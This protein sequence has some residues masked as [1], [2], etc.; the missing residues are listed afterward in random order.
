M[1]QNKVKLSYE[2]LWKFIIRPPRDEYTEDMLGNQKFKFHGKRYIRKDYEIISSQGYIMKC[3]LIEP[4]RGYRPFYEMP[5]VL[6]LHG[7]SSSRIEGLNIAHELLKRNINLFVVDFP[8]C[9][10]SEG[11]YISLGYHESDDVGIIIDFL[12]K[13]PGVGKIGM[14]GRSM[15]AATT[16]IYAHRDERVKAICMDSPFADFK[17][18]AKEL[19]K[20]QINIPDFLIDAVLSFVRTTVI[21]KNGLDI[22]KLKPLDLACKTHQPA[23]FLHAIYDELINV[24]HSIDLFNE[25]GGEKSLKCCDRGGH[26]SKRSSN[27]I[28]EIGEFFSKYLDNNYYESKNVDN[29]IVNYDNILNNKNNINN[30]NSINNTSIKGSKNNNELS[31]ASTF[32]EDNIPYGDNDNYLKQKEE[33]EKMQLTQMKQIFSSIQ[34][35]DFKNGILDLKD[36]KVDVPNNSSFNNNQYNSNDNNMKNV[37]NNINDEDDLID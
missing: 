31:R 36:I 6:Y 8:G 28:K 12:E 2:T 3:S 35:D 4:D 5:I 29:S 30:K 11:N 23:I 1:E 15:G 17:R 20:K 33:S 27:I 14:W 7:N 9:G 26:N 37:D 16:M 22:Y 18:L 19:T 25:Y 13:I 21:N 32:S 34:Q 10:L 24:Q